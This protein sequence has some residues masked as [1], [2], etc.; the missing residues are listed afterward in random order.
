MNN[1]PQRKTGYNISFFSENQ[2]KSPPSA[3]SE[4]VLSYVALMWRWLLH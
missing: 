2:R 1:I 4:A 3:V